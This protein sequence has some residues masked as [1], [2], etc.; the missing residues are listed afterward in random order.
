MNWGK[1]DSERGDLNV[2]IFSAIKGA[3]GTVLKGGEG[4]LIMKRTHSEKRGDR[5][6]LSSKGKKKKGEN[7]GGGGVLDGGWSAQLKG[8]RT[9]L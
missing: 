8:K 2:E 6:L 5:L 3:S 7:G 9:D 4:H 1:M